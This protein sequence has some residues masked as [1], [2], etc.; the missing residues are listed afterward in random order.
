MYKFSGG[1]MRRNAKTMEAVATVR[2]KP[3]VLEAPARSA[4]SAQLTAR[5]K[6]YSK[7]TIVLRGPT[8]RVKPDGGLRANVSVYIEILDK[9][10]RSGSA[11]VDRLRTFVVESLSIFNCFRNKCIPRILVSNGWNDVVPVNASNLCG[12][13]LADNTSI[14]C[15]FIILD[16]A[17]FLN[18]QPAALLNVDPSSTMIALYHIKLIVLIDL[19]TTGTYKPFSV[20]LEAGDTCWRRFVPLLQSYAM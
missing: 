8:S 17:Y 9:V 16:Q 6:F 15:F 19:V 7:T 18:T 3:H 11:G 20:Q 13:W 12:F 10:L 14:F 1:D 5:S 2:A 4:K